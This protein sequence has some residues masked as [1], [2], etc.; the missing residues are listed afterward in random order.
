MTYDLTQFH[1]LRPEWLWLLIPLILLIISV[2]HFNQQKSSWQK[3]VSPHLLAFL[4]QSKH[5]ESKQNSFWMLGLIASL[6]I[7][8]ISGP[9]FRQKPVP[10][11]KSESARVILLDLSLSMEVADIKPSRV[12]R[13]KHKIMDILEQNKEGSIALLVYAGDAFIISPLTTDANTIATM[14]PMLSTGIMPVLGSRP[15]LAINKAIELLNNAHQADGQIIWLT[16]GIDQ[17]Y[18]DPVVE[19]IDKNKAVLSILAIGTEQGAPIPLPDK[20]GFLKDNAG[21]IILPKLNSE[22]LKQ[23]AHQTNGQYTELT[24][25][26]QDVDLIMQLMQLKKNQDSNVSEDKMNRWIDDGYWLSWPIILTFLFYL[27]GSKQSLKKSR[28]T[29]LLA[30]FLSSLMVA[31]F[32]SPT[33]QA[34]LWDDLWRTKNQQAQSAFSKKDYANAAKLFEDNQWKAASEYRKG[35]FSQATN[36]FAELKDTESTYNYANSLAKSQQFKKAIETYNKVLSQ[37]PKHED[38]L[39]NKKLVEELLKQQQKQDQKQNEKDQEDQN[40]QSDQQKQSDKN[41]KDDQ[42][43]NEQQQQDNKQ[44]SDKDKD[45]KD[46]SKTEAQKE[47]EKQQ[48]KLEEDKR[49]QS[50]KDQALE[51]WLDKIPDD[52]GGLLRRKMIREYQQRGGKQK[53]KKLW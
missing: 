48:A 27:F 1:W 20:S 5:K 44:P 24:Q 18:I 21:N 39:F 53:E 13:A 50:E 26:Q 25:N 11:F 45:K 28:T 17:E 14:I 22:N 38:A 32:Y 9:S 49:E 12:I 8:S 3:V 40:K 2:H 7:V 34:N 41:T 30:L 23:I 42:Q 46:E 35:D 47:Q 10:V 29:N 31:S 16:D 51:H 19:A 15:D 4:I 33:S 37:N 43:Q 52:P 6:I 36:H